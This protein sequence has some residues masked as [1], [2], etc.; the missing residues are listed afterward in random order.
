MNPIWVSHETELLAEARRLMEDYQT[1]LEVDL[2]FQQF[3]EEMA[4]LPGRYGPPDGALLLVSVDGQ[5]VGCGA[6]RD[7]GGGIVEVK[8]MYLAPAMRGQGAG[9]WL[10]TELLA[11]AR[12]LGYQTARL[13]TLRRLTPAVR[14][15]ENAGFKEI[16]AYNPNPED[17]I[18][19]YEL[20]L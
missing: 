16:P 13:D 18:V 11:Q 6:L 7:L 3:D 9:K 20:A 10:L 17:D 8:R 5:Y 19:Y 4:T 14:L 2:C 15:Y 1:E 12:E